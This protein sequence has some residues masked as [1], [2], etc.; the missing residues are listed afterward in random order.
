MINEPQRNLDLSESV[1]KALEQYPHAFLESKLGY[2]KGFALHKL[3]NNYLDTKQ[4]QRAKQSYQKTLEVCQL[5]NALEER[6][7]QLWS[8]NIYH[9]LG[10]VAQE[11]REYKEAR[12]NYQLALQIN[13]EFGDR[14][15]CARTHHHL[16]MI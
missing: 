12:R 10:W 6:T 8:A 16:G 5:S 9:H 2:Q 11:L 1:Y 3:A 13:I 14:Y 7:K 4:Y 15:E